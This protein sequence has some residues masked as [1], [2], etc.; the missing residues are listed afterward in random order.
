MLFPY[1]TDAPI[2]YWPIATVGTIVVNVLIFLAIFVMPEELV[3]WIGERFILIYGTWNPVQWLTSNY[4]HGGWLH[5]IGNMFVLWGI[6]IIVEGK[7]GWWRFLLLYNGLGI[8]QC[9]VEQ[10]LMLFAPEGGSFG[11]SAIIFGLIAIVMLWAPRNELDCLLIFGRID[12]MEVSVAGYA[13]F[14]IAVQVILGILSVW[15]LSSMGLFIGVTSEILHL[16][17][18]AS[19]FAVGFVMLRLGWVDCEN[20]DLFSVWQGRH[21]MSREQLAE[22]ALTSEEAQAKLAQHFHQMQQQFQNYLAAGE[23]GAALSVHSR[24]KIQFGSS[25]QIAEKQHVDLISGLRKAQNWEETAKMM[26]EY[27]RSQTARAPLI[28]LALAQLLIEQLQ[29]PNQALKVLRRLDASLL[30]PKQQPIYKQLVA[31]AAAAAAEDPF[32]VSVEDW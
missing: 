12:T 5:L 1:N 28:R 8:F 17:G 24:G 16:M 25:W 32:E 6:G 22:E 18:A 29:R 2:Y 10:T 7:I 30:P 3:E 27:L 13:G 4:L 20:W 11:A 23:A 21:T 31:R 26:V 14:S 19:G 9:G 15:T